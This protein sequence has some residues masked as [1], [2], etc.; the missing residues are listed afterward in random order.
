MRM[1][2]LTMGCAMIG[3]IVT[4]WGSPVAQADDASFVQDLERIGFVQTSDSLI[5]TAK[6]A[7]Y[8]LRLKRD[9]GQVT[10]RIKRYLLVP[11]DWAQHFFVQAVHEYCPQYGG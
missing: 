3:M 9:P 5:E 11:E 2:A 6:S 4:L 1:F 7:C 8:F 10:D